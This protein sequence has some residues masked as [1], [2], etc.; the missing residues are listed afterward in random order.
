ME[1][2]HKIIEI[3]P[4]DVNSLFGL[5]RYG[6]E[7]LKNVA[8]LIQI[9]ALSIMAFQLSVSLDYFTTILIYMA[10]VRET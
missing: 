8:T 10:S 2:G 3:A 1:I 5:K 4:S 9:C 7:L 6:E